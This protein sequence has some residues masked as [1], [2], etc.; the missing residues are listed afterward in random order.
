MDEFDKIIASDLPELEKLAKAYHWTVT[1]YIHAARFQVELVQSMEDRDQ[2][3][4]EQIKLGVMESAWDMF[5]FCFL[6]VTG[7][8][9]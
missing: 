3:I 6:K 2:M 4:K 1:Q 9:L 5:E 7:R 8:K